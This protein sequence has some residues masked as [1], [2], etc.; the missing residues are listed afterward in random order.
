MKEKRA[1]G[2]MA[3]LLGVIGVYIFKPFQEEP[4]TVAQLLVKE[5]LLPGDNKITSIEVVKGADGLLYADIQ[6]FYRGGSAV[7]S[8]RVLADSPAPQSH[9]YYDEDQ[10]SLVKKG[11]NKVRIEIKRP[12]IPDKEFTSHKIKVSFENGVFLENG[13][14]AMKLDKEVDYLI[15]WPDSFSYN[16]NRNFSKKTI[17][18][19]Y[20][21]AVELIDQSNSNTFG[22]A[23][24]NLERILLK[25]PAYIDAYPELARFSMKNKWGPEG[26]KQAETYLLSGLALQKDHT[27]S[28][29]LLGYVYTHQSRFDEAEQE[30]KTAEK[31]GTDNLWLWANWG[32]L[33]AL[34]GSRERSVETYL[35]AI[36]APRPYNTYDRA[37]LDAYRKLFS[38]LDSKEGLVKADE[39]YKKRADEYPNQPCFHTDHAAFRIA[40]YADYQGAIAASRRAIDASCDSAES[41]QVMGI[42]NYLAWIN[43]SG[44]Q[45][46][47][48]LAQAQVFFPESPRLVY[49]LSKHD[50]TS[51][52]LNELKKQFVSVDTKDND[53]LNALAFAL[54][55]NNIA[56]ARRLLK[57]GAQPTESVSD[58]EYPVAMIPIFYQ[59]KEGVQLMLESG[60]NLSAMKY[61]GISALGYAERL[62]NPEILQL[63]KSKF[64]T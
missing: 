31:L 64:K 26:L 8:L 19:L 13:T 27:N 48:Y 37:R 39:L 41:R 59:H 12:P 2:L 17:N 3:V 36:S 30:F 29:V 34:Q 38:L 24:K 40:K 5:D 10:T 22:Q 50:S 53:N 60:V 28:H 7:P 20:T 6:Y 54:M 16:Q 18:E 47:T 63:I 52:V 21:E 4:V 11:E 61:R 44:E 57:L 43:T 46:N 58:Q 42:A 25:D 62:E 33:H 23:K 1:A 32:E 45:G 35:K 55:E 56:S 9:L 49:Q 14:S 51:K 15:E